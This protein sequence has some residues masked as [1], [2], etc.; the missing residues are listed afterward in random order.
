M[1]TSDEKRAIVTRVVGVYAAPT[2]TYPTLLPDDLRDLY[3]YTVDGGH[4]I[5]IAPREAQA[6]FPGAPVVDLLVPAPVRAVL[7][8]GW[9]VDVAGYVWCD[10]PY[11]A[12][13]G[14]LTEPEDDEY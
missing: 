10:L 6:Q 3:V 7:R 2:T 14:L 11:D 12:T 9:T 13:L 4:S 8:A 1:L 5:F